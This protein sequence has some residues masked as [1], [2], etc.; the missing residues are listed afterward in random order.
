MTTEQLT[1][2]LNTIQHDASGQ[3][4]AWRTVGR[5]ILPSILEEIAA[6]IVDDGAILVRCYT[7]TD[8]QRYRWGR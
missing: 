6:K 4:H 1:A 2:L 3:G 5:T 8:G 7:A